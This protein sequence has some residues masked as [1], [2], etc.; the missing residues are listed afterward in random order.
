MIQRIQSLYLFAALVL[1]ALMAFILS[2]GEISTV[3]GTV[4]H[5]KITDIFQ[6][7]TGSQALKS[8]G[9]L[10]SA[11][12]ALFCNIIL[13]LIILFMFKNRKRQIGLCY[14]SMV[15]LLCTEGIIAYFFYISARQFVNPGITFNLPLVFPV[16]AMVLI[17][18]AARYIKKDEALVKS[19]DRIR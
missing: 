18:F 10:I 7:G 1:L 6:P 12:I 15:I 5:L 14:L 17:Y 3:Q 16:I 11:F 9:W 8:S 19:V 4:Y 2:L 13:L